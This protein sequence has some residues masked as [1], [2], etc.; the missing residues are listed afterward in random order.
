MFSS[1]YFYG[2]TLE[3]LA[4]LL[5]EKNHD[6]VEVLEHVGSASILLLDYIVS[7]LEIWSLL[8]ALA[9]VIFGL[10]SGIDCSL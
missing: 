7:T 8:Q 10:G 3:F 6:L 5:L 4:F 9:R 1:F 2:R